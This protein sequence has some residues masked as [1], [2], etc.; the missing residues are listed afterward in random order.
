MNEYTSYEKL[1]EI[2]TTGTQQYEIAT[3]IK[4]LQEKVERLD[5]N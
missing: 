4:E 2:K 3:T 5:F 1:Y